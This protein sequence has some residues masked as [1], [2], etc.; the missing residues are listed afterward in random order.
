ML[1][2]FYSRIFL[3]FVQQFGRLLIRDMSDSFAGDALQ[4]S[5]RS[6][7]QRKSQIRM[8]AGFAEVVEREATLV[9][10]A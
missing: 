5:R 10:A 1:S 9:A 3:Q 6:V 4:E 8:V 2:S 7:L